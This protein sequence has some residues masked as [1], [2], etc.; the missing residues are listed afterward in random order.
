M[1]VAWIADG[2]DVNNP[3]FIRADG[4]HVFSDYQDFSG[5]DPNGAESGDEA[6]G[7][8]SSIAAQG[9]HS[10]DLSKYV[11][12]NH[13]LP[14]GCNIT[15]RGVAPGASLVGL[16][17]FGAANLVFDSTVVQAIDYAV[18]VDNV[19]V[20]NESLG[21]NAEPTQGLD[22]TSLADDA[23]VAAGVTVVTSTGDGGVTNT[24]GQPAVDPNVISVGA[25]TTFRR[26]VA[27]RHRRRAEPGE[28]LGLEQ[29]RGA[30]LLRHQRPGPGPGPGRAGP[31]R[32]GA[33]QPRGPLQRLRGLQRQPGLAG[34]LRRHQHGLAAGR[35]R[36]RAGHRGV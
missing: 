20:I 23:A 21:S 28:Q 1:K 34:G 19:D 24:E 5:T 33:V 31:G 11:M 10:Y 35:R 15:V 30:V 29:H 8:A 12:P 2:L 36:R 13:P 17:V 32:L 22:V 6:F 16:N 18:N 9:L 27:D 4:S 26:P 7:D 14:A 25:T 3:D